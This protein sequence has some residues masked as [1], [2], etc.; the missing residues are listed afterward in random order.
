VI[1]PSKVVSIHPYF[2]VK[3]GKL[4]EAKARLP[5]FVAKTAQEPGNLFYDFTVRDDVIF[6][7]EAYDGAEGL[8]KHVENVGALLGEMLTLADL[9][10]LEVHGS[11]VEL[12]KLKAP[13]A[14][15]NPEWFVFEC[16]VAR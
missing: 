4:A 11:A 13:L 6:C 2:R 5:Q 14:N 9:A 16:G 7:R 12:E 1:H 15:L 10:R 8:L 3:P